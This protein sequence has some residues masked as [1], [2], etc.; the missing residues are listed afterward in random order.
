MR[1]TRS[2]LPCI[3]VAMALAACGGPDA[4][5]TSLFPLAAGHR[6]AYTVTT[7]F[8]GQT[9]ERETLHLEAV[10]RD[11]LDGQPTWRRRSASGA[12]YWLRSDASG[13]YRVA[14]KSDLDAAPIADAQRRYV[15]KAPLAVGTQWQA[16]TVPYLLRRRQEFPRELRH[17]HPALPM[18]YAIEALG[19]HLETP[20]GTFEACV[21]V[22]GT[23]R[24]RV[25]ADAVVGWR[26]L[27]LTT[28]EWYCPGVGLA[29]LE[30]HE[31][32]SST[33]L[34]GGTLTMELQSW[35]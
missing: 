6:W 5:P 8:T 12:D 16:S 7:E 32:A 1:V 29:R 11:D 23:A 4:E 15:L 18:T 21:R 34:E 3:A 22:R 20:A 30:R 31:P 24:A 2:V 28:L 26:D 13:I 17:S 33:F 25:Y 10:G 27:P 14:S 35:R 9:P 19:Q